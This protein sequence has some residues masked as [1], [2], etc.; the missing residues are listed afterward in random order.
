MIESEIM[1]QDFDINSLTL[2]NLVMPKSEVISHLKALIKKGKELTESPYTYNEEP[3]YLELSKWTEVVTEFLIRAFDNSTYAVRFAKEKG[4]YH[5]KDAYSP[6]T[7]LKSELQAKLAILE[8]V[9]MKLPFI[10]EVSSTIS[11]AESLKKSPPA[12]N[13][14][15]V[16]IV[17]GHDVEVKISVARML[18]KV[19]LEAI[20]LH[21][22]P[23]EGRT[24]IEKIENQA[25]DIDFAVV[26]L[27]PDDIGK[28]SSDVGEATPRARQNVIAELGYFVGIL[29]RDKVCV[30]H[31][32]GVVIPTDFSG[33][34]YI[35]YDQSGSW[36]YQLAKELKQAD[37]KIDLNKLF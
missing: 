21:E 12:K 33:V 17:H 7:S 14:A 18:E 27:T 15:K 1:I 23:S 19:G 26:L 13:A 10:S 37:I 30:I 11:K 29:G 35:P 4:L 25:T 8:S 36:Q 24:I 28:S 20:I 32:E 34:V 6:S 16:F 22:Q 9:E 5:D 3:L 2:T 31:K